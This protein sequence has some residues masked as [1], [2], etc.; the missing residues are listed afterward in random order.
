MMLVMQVAAASGLVAFA[1]SQGGA[2]VAP[3]IGA[4]SYTI[5]TIN[6]S[7]DRNIHGVLRFLDSPVSICSVSSAAL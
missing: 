5:A 7:F 6:N 3:A 4:A 2:Y 1:S